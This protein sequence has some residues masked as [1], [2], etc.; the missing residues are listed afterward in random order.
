MN[1]VSLVLMDS[2]DMRNDKPRIPAPVELDELDLSLIRELQKDGRLALTKLGN[3]LSVSH[4]TIRNR[5]E[6]LLVGGSVPPAL[7][8]GRH[9]DGSNTAP[10]HFP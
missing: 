7:S 10:N 9:T 3:R 6:R 2:I 4:G 5:L 1:I 8:P